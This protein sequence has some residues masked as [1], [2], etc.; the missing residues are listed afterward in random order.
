MATNVRSKTRGVKDILKIEGQ[1]LSEREIALIKKI[2]S[3]L[4][5]NVIRDYEIIKKIEF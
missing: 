5:I 4:T 1:I 3:R 2:A